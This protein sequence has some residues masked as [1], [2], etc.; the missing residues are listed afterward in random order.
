MAQPP[1]GGFN[2]KWRPSGSGTTSQK[3]KEAR[4]AKQWSF[5]EGDNPSGKKCL[6][7]HLASLEAARKKCL[8][9]LQHAEEDEALEKAEQAHKKAMKKQKKAKQSL[10]KESLEKD[11]DMEEVKVEAEPLEKGKPGKH[12]PR[13]A[14]LVSADT[15]EKE[16]QLKAKLH[17]SL[18][19]ER[20]Y[21]AKLQE[22]L[23]KAKSAAGTGASSSSKPAGPMQSM[24]LYDK[25]STS[26]AIFNQLGEDGK[27]DWAC[28]LGCTV[29]FDDQPEIIK[30]A[31]QWGLDAYG[32]AHPKA[33]HKGQFWATFAEAVLDYLDKLAQYQ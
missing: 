23:E 18:E 16:R 7:K 17:A 8:D 21:T 14:S 5:L 31:K 28:H 32:I 26:M 6:E 19:K 12:G 24:P 13:K 1:P 9:K 27:V 33:K 4:E 29:I 15:L 11:V 25:L 10:E 22:A 2:N 30:E 3:R 20:Q